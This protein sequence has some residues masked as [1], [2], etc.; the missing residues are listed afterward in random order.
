MKM[1][2]MGAVAAATLALSST[3][4]AADSNTQETISGASDSAVMTQ[5]HDVK[6]E[7]KKQKQTQ[8]DENKRGRPVNKTA[9]AS[10]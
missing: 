5:T 7:K 1:S 8:A 10:N 2:L 6:A 9:P 4:F 3:T